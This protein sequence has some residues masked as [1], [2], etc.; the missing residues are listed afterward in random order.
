MGATNT[1]AADT[2]YSALVQIGGNSFSGGSGND[3]YSFN[4]NF[5]PVLTATNSTTNLSVNGSGF[6]DLTVSWIMPD[7]SVAATVNALGALNNAVQSVNLPL[8]DLLNQ[9]WAGTYQLVIHW[10]LAANTQGSY[11]TQILT[12]FVDSETPLPLPPALLL[13]GSAL[14]GMTALGRRKRQTAV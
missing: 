4:Y 12:P 2:S 6:T 11:S 10:A 8:V 3:V 14:L 13:F 7:N 1:L 5:P 9:P